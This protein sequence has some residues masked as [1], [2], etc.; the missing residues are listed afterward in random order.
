MEALDRANSDLVNLFQATEVATVFLDAQLAIRS[1]TPATES[2]FSIRSNDIGRP[3]TD[4]SVRIE[5]PHF[6][7]DLQRALH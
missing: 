2:I 5:L 3:I 7:E 6:N 4:L 1:F